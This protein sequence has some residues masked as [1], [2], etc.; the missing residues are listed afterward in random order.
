MKRHPTEWEE[1][2]ASHMTDKRLISRIHKEFLQLN[3][4]TNSIKK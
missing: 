1:M 4:K 3:K 2:F